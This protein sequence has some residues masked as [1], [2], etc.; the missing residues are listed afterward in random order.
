MKYSLILL[1]GPSPGAGL[2]I[3]EDTTEVTL[4]RDAARDLPIDDHHCS[5]LH[6]RVW[7]DSQRWQVEDCG[8]SNGTFVNSRRIDRV[9]LRPGDIIRV[10]ETLIVFACEREDEAELPVRR[11]ARSTFMMR[12]SEPDEQ[13]DF[14]QPL[15]DAD[16]ELVRSA[17]VL[18]RLSASLHQLDNRDAVISAA[19]DAVVDAVGADAVTIWLAGADGRLAAVGGS[20]VYSESDEACVPVFASLAMEKNEAMLVQNNGGRHALTSADDTFHPHHADMLITV[21]IPGQTERCG[22]IEC[23]RRTEHGP[24]TQDDLTV[25]VAIAHQVG[26]ALEN[27][28]HRERLELANQH[29][30]SAV[31]SQHRIV[32]DSPVIRRLFDTIARVGPVNSTILVRGE[33]GTGKEL[34]A[35]MIHEC[36]RRHSGPYVPINC[37]AFSESL[38]ESELFGHEKGAFTGA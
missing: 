28:Q 8:S 18:C 11:M 21:P 26:M 5:R 24:L 36:S 31:H 17:A 3:T 4:G 19:S 7:F 1:N 16:S 22:A 12:V 6:A 25:V 29:L 35:R 15:L 13:P 23:G 32:G 2:T 10:G 38:L 14:S 34:V 9:T 30:R 33:S 37:A 20:A 27:L